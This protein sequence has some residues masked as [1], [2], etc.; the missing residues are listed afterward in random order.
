MSK[1][2]LSIILKAIASYLI[3][4]GITLAYIAWP[5]FEGHA[6]APFTSFPSFLVFSPLIPLFLIEDGIKETIVFLVSFIVL[7]CLFI[8]FS[9][10]TSK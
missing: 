6:H 5:D 3:A 8:W 10:N 2:K 7:L 4:G 9:K 1:G